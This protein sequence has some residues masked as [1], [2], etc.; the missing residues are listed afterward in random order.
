M[1]AGELEKLAA[2]PGFAD[3]ALKLDNQLCFA[4]YA[5]SKEVVRRYKPFLDQLGITYTQYIALMVLWE[6]DG[7]SVG[8]L[9]ERLLLDSGTLTPLLKKM[10]SAGLVRRQRSAGDERRV[11]VHLTQAGR[12]LKSQAAR[13]PLEMAGCV[14]LEPQEAAQLA[15]LLRKVL[16]NV[17]DS[18]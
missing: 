14:Q 12:N 15:G 17:R 1:K 6:T 18:R 7:V 8:E 4:L 9:G 13:V 11:E 5:C 3:E 10:E 16:A 2:R